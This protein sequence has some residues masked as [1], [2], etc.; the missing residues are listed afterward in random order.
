MKRRSFIKTA[1]IGSVAITAAGTIPQSV[2]GATSKIEDGFVYQKEQKVPIVKKADVVVCGGGP[3]GVGAAIEAARSGAKTVLIESAGFL[4]GTWTAGLLGVI[5]DTKGKA[6]LLKEL[7]D[8]LTQRQWRVTSIGTGNLFTFEVEKMKILLEEVCQQAGVDLMYYTNV[9]GSIVKKGKITHVLTNSKS[10]HQA[11]EGKV[12][13]DAT[14]DGDLAA[15]SGCKYD[16]GNAQGV[17]QPMS[18]LGVLSGVEFESIKEFVLCDGNSFRQA[19]KKLFNEILK[20]GY[21]STYENPC[22]FMLN[23]DVFVLMATHQYQMSGISQADLTK[24]S[25][26][27]RK[28]LQLILQSL[29]TVGGPWVNLNVVGTASQIGV[30]DTRRIHGLYTVCEQDLVEGKKHPDAVC[31]VAQNVDVHPVQKAHEANASYRQGVKSVPYEIPMGAII[32]KDVQGL[33]M[34]GRCISG[35]FIAQSSYRINSNSVM[36][37]QSAGRIAAKAA[38]IGI[39]PQNVQ[40]H[41]SQ[42]D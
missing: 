36:L 26:A 32:A 19:K 9:T 35:D 22:L 27:G 2:W 13:I 34:V 23:K 1:G 11:I 39:L 14:G 5:L 24:A 38:K 31:T 25:I 29:R 16:M 18:M 20:G 7:M 28:E 12:F 21:H 42:L 6:G 4:G 8:T 41:Y 17:T 33:M 3:S 40:F 30:R 15:M 10:G 37:G